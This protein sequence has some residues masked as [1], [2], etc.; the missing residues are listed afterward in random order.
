[1][2]PLQILKVNWLLGAVQDMFSDNL[3]QVV[4]KGVYAVFLLAFIWLGR[5]IVSVPIALVLSVVISA[6]LSWVLF[7]RSRGHITWKIDRIFVKEIAVQGWTVGVAGAALQSNA[8]IDKIIVNAYR[9]SL[10]TCLYGASFRLVSAVTT[11]GTFFTSAVFPASCQRYHESPSSLGTFI[12][13]A[14]RLLMLI[15]LPCI[16][17]LY[18]FSK[19]IV[20][21][22]L[23]KGYVGSELSFNIT[24]WAAGFATTSRPTIIHW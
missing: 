9:G 1:M 18:A 7:L 12:S 5:S 13:Y 8:N 20:L 6:A 16:V 4:E 21:L 23:G 3:V 2:I 19:E 14:S 24:V 11:A 15:T 17:V 10:Q 22:L